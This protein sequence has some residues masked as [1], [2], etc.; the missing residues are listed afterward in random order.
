[1]PDRRD[2]T[3]AGGSAAIEDALSPKA[4]IALDVLPELER[5]ARERQGART[6]IR[7]NI[8]ESPKGK[9]AEQAAA[10]V[11]VNP[12]YVSDAKAIETKAIGINEGFFHEK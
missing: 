5:E 3:G 2:E 10:L 12:H 4:M 11:S 1:M 8:P 7:E 9:A 6:D